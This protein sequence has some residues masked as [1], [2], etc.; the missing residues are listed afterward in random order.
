MLKKRLFSNVYH[1]IWP[2]IP[3]PHVT[4]DNTYADGLTKAYKQ[5]HMSMINNTLYIAGSH[6]KRDWY[7]DITKI[8]N[9]WT[10]VG[11]AIPGMRGYNMC[12]YGL[13]KVNASLAH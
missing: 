10:H 4:T 8:S 9:A 6:R 5:G 11:D 2:N 7:D 12:I 3:N 13:N 1:P